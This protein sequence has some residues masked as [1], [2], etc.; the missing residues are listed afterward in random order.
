M[1][2]RSSGPVHGTRADED[3]MSDLIGDSVYNWAFVAD[4]GDRYGGVI[5]AD[6]GTFLPGQILDVPY[7][8]YVIGDAYAYGFDLGAYY[9]IDEGE[10]YIT[11]YVDAYQGALQT[12]DYPYYG[13]PSS[14]YGLGYEHDYAWN[15]AYWDDFGFG[16]AYQAGYYG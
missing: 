2:L 10:T 5:Y 13:A 12:F 7:G 11:Y 14:I 15:G 16:G 4:S 8:Y 3:S 6:T 9:G 1:R